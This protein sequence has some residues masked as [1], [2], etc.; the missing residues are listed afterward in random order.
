MKEVVGQYKTL[1]VLY[2]DITGDIIVNLASM[3]SIAKELLEKLCDD[4]GGWIDYYL[5]ELRGG[6]NYDDSFVLD[7][8]GNNVR[9]K[10]ITDLWNLLNDK[11]YKYGNCNNIE[12]NN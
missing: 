4:K 5:Y 3:V 6:E 12:G 11:R 10:T 7:N 8:E 1:L 9:L 2:T